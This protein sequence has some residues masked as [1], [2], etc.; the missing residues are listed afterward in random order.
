MISETIAA[1]LNRLQ[2]FELASDG[3]DAMDDTLKQEYHSLQKEMVQAFLPIMKRLVAAGLL[4]V[5]F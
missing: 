3:Y 1:Q 5:S 2:L 4:T